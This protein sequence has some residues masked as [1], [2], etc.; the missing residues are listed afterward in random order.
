MTEEVDERAGAEE[1]RCPGA[2]SLESAWL[3]WTARFG[4]A[5]CGLVYIAIGLV[6][7]AVAVGLA[8]Q[9][10]GSRG[11][12]RLIA[13][14]PFGRWMV[15]GLGA[16]L[17]SYATL[18]FAG[19]IR[20]P[21][22]RGRSLRGVAIRGADA[23]TGAVYVMLAAAGLRIVADP[24]H[25]GS[26]A[27]L[28]WAGDVLTLP[29]GTAVLALIGVGLVAS[30]A[31]VLRRAGAEPFEEKFDRRTLRPLALRV[32]TLAARAGTAARGVIFGICG[33]LVIRTAMGSPPER[34]GTVGHAL[35]AIGRTVIGHWLLG[36]VAVGFIA[37]GAYQLAKVRYRRM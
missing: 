30:G 9:A 15:I 18:N 16:G 31:F 23:L 21:D 11:V 13:A 26:R 34:A 29:F 4:F 22:G 28:A 35:D 33:V 32:I 36:V 14:Q 3:L 24:E 19:A 20:D 12:L 10:R 8:E 17:I 7:G 1:R 27:A 25:D 2:R 6:A 37:Y 5:A